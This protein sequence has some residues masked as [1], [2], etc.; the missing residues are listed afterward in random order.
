MK[1]DQTGGQTPTAVGGGVNMAPVRVT[2]KTIILNSSFYGIINSLCKRR[3]Q[4]EIRT[5]DNQ[6]NIK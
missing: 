1:T 2:S 5:N 4:G 6:E 3:T